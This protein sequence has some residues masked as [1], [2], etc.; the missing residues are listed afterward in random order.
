[1]EVTHPYIESLHSLYSISRSKALQ[2]S[3]PV[4]TELELLSKSV[5]PLVLRAGAFGIA[6]LV[7][8]SWVFIAR[9]LRARQLQRFQKEDA[10]FEGDIYQKM[11]YKNAHPIL[12]RV[13]FQEFPFSAGFGTQWAL[14]KSYAVP[15]GTKLLVK[16]GL[17]ACPATAGK[18]AED[19]GAIIGELIA[20]GL[21]SDRALKANAKMNWLHQRYGTKITNGDTIHTMGLFVLEPIR[22]IEEKEWRPLSYVE[23]VAIFVYWRELVHRMGAHDVP[24]TIEGLQE[25]MDEWEPK[26]MFY[27]ESNKQCVDATWALF[28][29]A[30]PGASLGMHSFFKKFTATFIQPHVRPML[31]MPDPPKWIEAATDGVFAIRRFLTRNFLLVRTHDIIAE[32]MEEKNGRIYRKKFLFEPWYVPETMLTKILSYLPFASKNL[33]G[34][35]FK[36]N[37]FSPEELGPLE[38]EE[39]SR[40]PAL[41]QAEELRKYAMTGGSQAHGCPFGKP[42]KDQSPWYRPPPGAE[43]VAA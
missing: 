30:I 6:A 31:G 18:R 2:I 22:F 28:L 41:K 20:N 16:T 9:W 7:G 15:A 32:V 12:K 13:F 35:Q 14:V 8:V 4:F 3:S 27:D 42:L 24:E 36:S 10:Q 38:F 34:P 11:N 39:K 1:M 23:K 40:E 5:D 25:W 33:P 29:R 26:N 19:T 37:G 21:D 43:P 17:L